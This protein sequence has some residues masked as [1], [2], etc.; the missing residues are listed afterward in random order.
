[1]SAAAATQVRIWHQSYTDLS[2]LP[3]YAARIVAH[4]KTVLAGDSALDLHGL[5]EGAPLPAIRNAYLERL[6]DLWVCDAA[7]EA[8]RQG[9]DAVVL[10]CFYDPALREARSLVEIP[11]LGMAETAMLVACAVGRKFA[12]VSLSAAEA[13]AAAEL[14]CSYGLAERMACSISLKP[15]ITES[16]IESL[17]AGGGATLINAFEAACKA[18]QEFGAEVII[19]A[20]GVLNEFLVSEHAAGPGEVVVL[21]AIGVLW[22]QAESFIGMHRALGLGVSRQ[23]LDRKAT[24]P[25]VDRLKRFTAERWSVTPGGQA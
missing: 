25:E 19:P 11:V 3:V 16:E 9:Y 15:A 24:A 20:E 23:G 1:V 7:V 21:D 8:E 5:P 2:T 17:Q 10:G 14:V 4:A 18:G 12:I 6:T 13:T 22:K